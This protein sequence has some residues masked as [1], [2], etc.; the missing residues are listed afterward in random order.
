MKQSLEQRERQQEL[1]PAAF[2][3]DLVARFT[4]CADVLPVSSVLFSCTLSAC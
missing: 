1:G 4:Y 3:V 2:D